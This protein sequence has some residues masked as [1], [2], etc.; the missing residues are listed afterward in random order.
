M[1]RFGPR[2]GS[3]R[4]GA[5]ALRYF[6]TGAFL[7]WVERADDLVEAREREGFAPFVRRLATVSTFLERVLLVLQ[8]LLRSRVTFA[9][10][11]PRARVSKL[12]YA[13]IS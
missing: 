5:R 4:T 11:N 1:S 13:A 3:P 9:S 10:R 2:S 12:V 8:V 6:R 7:R